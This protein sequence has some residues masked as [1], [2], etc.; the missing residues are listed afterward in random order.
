MSDDVLHIALLEIEWVLNYRPLIKQTD[1]PDDR[2]FLLPSPTRLESELIPQLWSQ[3]NERPPPP[4]SQRLLIVS[5]CGVIS[6]STPAH[7]QS[8]LML[9]ILESNL[10]EE[11]DE[12]VR[13]ASIRSLACLT[14]LISDWDKL[15][16]LVQRLNRLL[17]LAPPNPTQHPQVCLIEVDHNSLDQQT[18]I[19]SRRS[20]AKPTFIT[21]VDWLLPAVAQW[22]L[23][24]DS[25]HTTLI[26]PWLDH[27]DTYIL[28]SHSL[29]NSPVSHEMVIHTLS[30]LGYLVPFLHAWSLITLIRPQQPEQ[31]YWSA[32]LI[33]ASTTESAHESPAS[34]DGRLTSTVCLGTDSQ[35]SSDPVINVCLILGSVAFRVLQENFEV[36]LDQPIGPA[37]SPTKSVSETQ[38]PLSPT[39]CTKE[40][41]VQKWAAKMW[42][43]TILLP[44][45]NELLIHVSASTSKR[46]MTDSPVSLYDHKGLLEAFVLHQYDAHFACPWHISPQSD[47]SM[48]V[49]LAVCQFLTTFGVSLGPVGVQKFLAVPLQTALMHQTEFGNFEF[50]HHAVQTGLL[51]GY[52][53]LM[54]SVKVKPLTNKV[55]MLLTNAIFLHIR[56]CYP[57]DSIRLTF[58]CLCFTGDLDYILLELIIPALRPCVG[59]ADSIVRRASASLLHSVIEAVRCAQISSTVNRTDSQTPGPQPNGFDSLFQLISQVARDDLTGQRKLINPDEADWSVLAL[60][61]GPLYS[62]LTFCQK[63][64]P[65]F[66]ASNGTT[67]ADASSPAVRFPIS[68]GLT[69]TER[70]P[71]DFEE[72]LYELIRLQ[73]NLVIGVS[74]SSSLTEP[75]ISCTTIGILA[76]QQRF[77]PILTL[78]LLS[79]TDHLLPSCPNSFR[80][81]G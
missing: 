59:C 17:L 64:L 63:G 51:A 18:T 6:P 31:T 27:L 40:H 52:C 71:V 47:P 2:H 41:L 60:A 15:P 29:H 66:S 77:W 70:V 3:L 55:R 81:K 74:D 48:S 65:S 22:C 44:K 37:N 62:F 21:T 76:A 34:E 57:L 23:E 72:Q 56:E 80:D 78:A 61:T 24:L 20:S 13:A 19:T 4:I 16:H 69:S 38:S 11:R 49:C 12:F 58:W 7:L 26:D 45:L 5:A 36:I 1:D 8:S 35:S 53:C 67:S 46:S 43:Q 25:L 32:A 68:D 33:W 73:F 30:M 28:A 75:D 14:C 39:R 79:L 54:A 10:N 42:L 50:D 9:S